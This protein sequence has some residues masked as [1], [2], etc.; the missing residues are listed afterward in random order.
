MRLAHIFEMWNGK[1]SSELV[2]DIRRTV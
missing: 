1:I 2:Y